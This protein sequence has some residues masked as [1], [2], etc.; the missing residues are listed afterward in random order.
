MFSFSCFNWFFGKCK[1]TKPFDLCLKI[2]NFCFKRSH[3]FTEIQV[4]WLEHTSYTF[5]CVCL[6]LILYTSDVSKE[7]SVNILFRDTI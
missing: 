3:S 6:N 2:K 1:L 5:E 4:R 7:F